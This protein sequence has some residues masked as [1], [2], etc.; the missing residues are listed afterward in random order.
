MAEIELPN[1][2]EAKER[3]EDPFTKMV[4]LC[5]AIYAVVLAIAAAG[6]NNAGKDMLME[7]QKA[8]NKWAQYQSKAIRE[9]LYINES[10]RIERDLDGNVTPE[11][12][13]KAEKSLA[14]IKGKLDEY[15]T[16]KSEIMKEAQAHEH[17][18]DDS[19]TRDPYFDFAEVLL[20]ISIVLASVAML[21]GKRWAFY[22][23]IALALL[24]LALTANGYLLFDGGK[25]F[26]SAAA[27]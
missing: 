9:A 1:P 11:A 5:V 24:G 14:R 4:A 18:R 21:S 27:H 12:K 25:L 23:S 19:H 8:S 20:Q 16:E 17:L 3:A 26:G 7:Q 2:H 15:K 10:E 13:A 6:G 22:A